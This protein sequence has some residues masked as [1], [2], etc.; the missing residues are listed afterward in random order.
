MSD[1][2]LQYLLVTGT[3]EAV[4]RANSNRESFA[5]A[6]REKPSKRHHWLPNHHGPLKMMRRVKISQSMLEGSLLKDLTVGQ[7]RYLY[8]IITIYNAVPLRR[9]LY[10]QHV[11]SLTR[12]RMMGFITDEEMDKFLAYLRHPR[13]QLYPKWP[14]FMVK[15]ATRGRR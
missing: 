3:E 11:N 2:L 6:W 5:I 10:Q 12:Q 15:T 8:S 4:I 14:L 13:Q 9:S 1:E 7:Q